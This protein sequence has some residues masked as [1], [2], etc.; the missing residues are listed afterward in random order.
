VL[1]TIGAGLLV[2]SFMG[3]LRMDLRFRPDRL[4]TAIIVLPP[5]RYPDLPSNVTFYRKLLDGLRNLPG[6]DS[7]GAVNGVPLSGN[8]TG[9]Y[10]TVE[11]HLRQRWEP[12]GHR[13]KCSRPAR[14]TCPQ[15]GSRYWRAAN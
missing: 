12:A 13:R 2:K 14:I 9:A 4:V 5:S 3:L 10:V 1:L 8:I 6:V 11:G 7:V 15:W